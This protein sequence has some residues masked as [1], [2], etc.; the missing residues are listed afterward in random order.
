LS[1][2]TGTDSHHTY[3]KSLRDHTV[4][5]SHRTQ[6][7]SLSHHTG[8]NSQHTHSESPSH[9]TGSD[10]HHTHTHSPSRHTHSDI[11]THSKETNSLSP[12]KHYTQAQHLSIAQL[13]DDR[14]LRTYTLFDQDNTNLGIQA[15]I[16]APAGTP[17]TL[18]QSLTASLE[19]SCPAPGCE[20]DYG[21][22]QGRPTDTSGS[23]Q[24]DMTW[25]SQHH[26]ILLGRFEAL[27][28]GT[29]LISFT[30]VDKNPC[31]SICTPALSPKLTPTLS[32]APDGSELI[33]WVS[34]APDRS[35][36]S[37]MAQAYLPPT[38]LVRDSRDNIP[39][40]D[41]PGFN[42]S[43]SSTTL[44]NQIPLVIWTWAGNLSDIQT[45]QVLGQF[46]S[47]GEKQGAAFFLNTQ[48]GTYLDSTQAV[49]ATQ[50]G[51]FVSAMVRNKRVIARFFT[52]N[53]AT[54]AGSEV[55][56][57]DSLLDQSEIS[58]S[59]RPAGGCI[60]NWR[61]NDSSTYQVEFSANR[62]A[63]SAPLLIRS[64][65]HGITHAYPLPLGL[66]NGQVLSVALAHNQVSNSTEI[67]ADT[68]ASRRKAGVYYLYQPGKAKAAISAPTDEDHPFPRQQ[69]K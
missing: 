61:R 33:A 7:R 14:T 40:S 22:I 55:P 25:V 27:S 69:F 50:D 6:S 23:V 29:Q 42:L 18:I 56:I 41:T 59:A 15:E 49:A 35:G 45:Y 54:A 20:P 12:P 67:V 26:F 46:F 28:N 3:S 58:V 16:C 52:D 38:G 13:S 39:V 64:S 36:A 48:P 30:L 10:S 1:H 5:D 31:V 60:F 4:T 65:Q 37:L 34:V 11:H 17:C 44:S 2:H 63:L 9:H 53:N 8:S 51:G 19:S 57:D 47:N 68:T 21:S 66:R 62:T 24:F 43:P 32:I